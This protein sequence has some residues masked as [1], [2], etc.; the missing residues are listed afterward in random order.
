MKRP[1]FQF[2]PADWRKDAAL[3]SCS[4]AARGLWIEAMCIAHECEPYGHLVVNGRPMNAAQIGRLVGLSAKE[5]AGL[6]DGLERAGVMSRTEDGAVFSRRMVRDEELRQ[7]RA[8]GGNEGSGHGEKGA[9][10]GAKGGRP[11][12]EKTPLETPLGGEARGDFNPPSPEQTDE[13]RGVLKNPIK[14]PHSSSSS[15]SSS[16]V[17][18]R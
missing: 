10:H 14:P 2:Y 6:L 17:Q 9:E 11:R 16:K 1:A 5:C 13:G 8:K 18:Q 4:V 15:S 12:K 3:Q 7:R